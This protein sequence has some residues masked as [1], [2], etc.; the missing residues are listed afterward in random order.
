MGYNLPEGNNSALD[1]D[2]MICQHC[3]RKDDV[4]NG[5]YHN[6]M[7]Y[8]D[9]CFKELFKVCHKCNVCVI[10]VDEEMCE[11]CL[12]EKT[13]DESAEGIFEKLGYKKEEIK[14]FINNI[15]TNHKIY[16]KNIIVNE[17]YDKQYIFEFDLLKK[18][19]I[20]YYK[21][22]AFIVPAPLTIE[23]LKAVIQFYKE[24]GWL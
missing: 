11:D 19:Y 17:L 9:E 12:A 3:D 24:Q 8:C 16:Y 1:N 6:H 18:E 21:S 4:D 14:E 15:T 2:D 20:H 7:W 22:V 10:S 23:E 5:E 13:Y